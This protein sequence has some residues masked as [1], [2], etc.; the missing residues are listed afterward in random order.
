MTIKPQRVKF[1]LFPIAPQP[2]IPLTDIKERQFDLIDRAQRLRGDHMLDR[3]DERTITALVDEVLD[4]LRT[5]LEEHKEIV[6]EAHAGYLD[7]CRKA[8]AKAGDKIA[9]M[10]AKLEAGEVT[11]MKPI[12]FNL[13]PPQDHSKDF[14]TT[15]KMMELHKAAHDADP[16]NNEGQPATFELKAVD[17]QRFILNDWSWMDQFLATNSAYS[18]KAA[19]MLSE[20]M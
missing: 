8:L 9:T 4:A 1:P 6:I 7:R 3:H 2:E 18:A 16:N 11:E 14:R 15:I 19:V 10:A 5:N 17:V 20:R 13:S 12:T